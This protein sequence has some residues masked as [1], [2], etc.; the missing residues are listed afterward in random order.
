MTTTAAPDRAI[1]GRR[2]PIS[3][4]LAQALLFLPLGLFQLGA[5]I[6][7]TSTEGVHGAKDWLVALWLPPMALAC[8]F[9][10]LRLGRDARMARV[11]LALL[12]A[13]AAFCFV[14]L[15]AYHESAAYVFFGFV[16]AA[17]GLLVLPASRRYVGSA[18]RR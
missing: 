7:F 11:A 13:Q 15:T 1:D 18:A 16:I 12:T 17:A 9:V 2:V 14:K 10:A 6:A 5:Y 8:A 3:L 4:R